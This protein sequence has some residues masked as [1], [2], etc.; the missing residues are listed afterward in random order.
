[1]AHP[2]SSPAASTSSEAN[3]T[4]WA[5]FKGRSSAPEIVTHC[6]YATQPAFERQARSNWRL[7]PGG[8][9]GL[10]RDALLL[11]GMQNRASGQKRG[12][13]AVGGV[14]GQVGGA[15]QHH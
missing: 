14:D 3:S 10:G 12:F 6:A 7:F 5:L 15:A 1:V 4:A 8:V 9:I 13:F 2:S 11:G